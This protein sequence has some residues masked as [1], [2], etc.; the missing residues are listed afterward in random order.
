MDVGMIP[1]PSLPR[2]DGVCVRAGATLNGTI[3]M[4]ALAG[5]RK[6]GEKSHA[7]KIA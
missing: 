6:A 1:Q 3:S 5:R 4:A 7:G 2:G